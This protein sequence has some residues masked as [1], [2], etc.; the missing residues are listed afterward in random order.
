MPLP[1]R[2]PLEAGECLVRLT[3][4]ERELL[5]YVLT[6]AWETPEMFAGEESASLS[7]YFRQSIA[8]IMEKLPRRGAGT[9]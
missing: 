8:R 6:R 3:R 7:R 4:E 5:H 9:Y 2:P 1:V